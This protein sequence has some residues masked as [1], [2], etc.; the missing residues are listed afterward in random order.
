M[1]VSSGLFFGLALLSAP[2]V[3]AAAPMPPK[4]AEVM[5]LLKTH[6]ISCHSTSKQKGG[7]SLETREA[8]LHGGDQG[9][10]LVRQGS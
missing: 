1:R 8:A 7:L 5:G 4:P 2:Q 3:F 6:C 9:A 10:S